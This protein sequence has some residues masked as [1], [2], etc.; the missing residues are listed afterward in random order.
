MNP[1]EIAGNPETKTEETLAKRIA[2]L[3]N[4]RAIEKQHEADRI[5]LEN[6]IDSHTNTHNQE[7]SAF[8]DRYRQETVIKQKIN[9]ILEQKKNVET[10]LAE[11][12]T[13]IQTIESTKDNISKCE[14]S[15]AAVLEDPSNKEYLAEQ[16][17]TDVSNLA[18]TFNDLPETKEYNELVSKLTAEKNKLNLLITEFKKEVQEIQLPD[19]EP[20]KAIRDFLKKNQEN[21]SQAHSELFDQTAEGQEY[22]KNL[23]EI[24]KALSNRLNDLK[25]QQTLTPSSTLVTQQIFEAAQPLGEEKLIEIL[26][27]RLEKDMSTEG[28]TQKIKELLKAKVHTDWLEQSLAKDQIGKENYFK[29]EEIKKNAESPKISNAIDRLNVLIDAASRIPSIP[30]EFEYAYQSKNLSNNVDWSK[31]K[32]GFNAVLVQ[33]KNQNRILNDIWHKLSDANQDINTAQKQKLFGIFGGPS[34]EQL[35]RQKEL[36]AEYNKA[37]EESAKQNN[38]VELYR[39]VY[40]LTNELSAYTSPILPLVHLYKPN[41]NA[42]SVVDVAKSIRSDL[43]IIHDGKLPDDEAKM[44]ET[45]HQ[46]YDEAQLAGQ[47]FINLFNK[48]K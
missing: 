7:A 1:N 42:K 45:W 11:V 33:E 27:Q 21:L 36:Q 47:E 31:V 35:A 23:A 48:Q 40:A 30:A 12:E 4:E 17:I 29:Q 8:E 13:S 24:Q 10:W 28:Y 32:S 19:E 14:Q 37:K 16:Q 20:E 26:Q 15:L 25:L 9:E 3:A 18:K 22:Q 39:T 44:A 34:S 38:I 2:R 43:Q 6:N 5:K 46:K 41:E